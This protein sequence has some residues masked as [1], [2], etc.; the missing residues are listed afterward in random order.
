MI[1]DNSASTITWMVE[2]IVIICLDDERV[3]FFSLLRKRIWISLSMY[4]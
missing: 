1:G 2:H 4:I 3:N